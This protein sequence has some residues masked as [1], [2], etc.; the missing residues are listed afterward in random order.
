MNVKFWLS[1]RRIF[2]LRQD[3]SS[4]FRRYCFYCCVTLQLC[5]LVSYGSRNA[6][7][8]WRSVLNVLLTAVVE[9]VIYTDTLH[10]RRRQSSV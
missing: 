8:R 4:S 10:T 1:I 9:N 6:A 3:S 7:R 5:L 2:N